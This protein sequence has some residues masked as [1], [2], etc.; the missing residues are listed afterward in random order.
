MKF[1]KRLGWRRERLIIPRPRNFRS[2]STNREATWTKRVSLPDELNLV[3]SSS[4]TLGIRDKRRLKG[5]ERERER[6]K[7][8]FLV[9]NEMLVVCRARHAIKSVVLDANPLRSFREYWR[10]GAR[11]NRSE[12]RLGCASLLKASER[13]RV[14]WGTVHR[15]TF[16]VGLAISRDTVP[17]QTPF[18]SGRRGPCCPFLLERISVNGIAADDTV[19]ADIPSISCNG[20]RCLVRWACCDSALSRMVCV[21]LLLYFVHTRQINK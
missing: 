15:R 16:R 9:Y 6:E 17:G 3:G 4:R 20:F 21:H 14:R 12:E 13:Y 2:I 7:K 8:E 1:L 5:K 19:F 11:L 10:T 18:H